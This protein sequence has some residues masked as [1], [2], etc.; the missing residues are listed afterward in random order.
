MTACSA[1]A[2][3]RAQVL[4]QGL[5]LGISEV[6]LGWCSCDMLPQYEADFTC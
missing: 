1:V 6:A 4:L 5:P 2:P 3:G